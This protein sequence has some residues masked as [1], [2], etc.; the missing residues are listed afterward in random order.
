MRVLILTPLYPGTIGKDV[1]AAYRRLEVMIAAIAKIADRLEIVHFVHPDY[2]LLELGSQQLNREQSEYW[3]TRVEVSLAPLRHYSKRRWWHR[4]LAILSYSYRD[5][6]F[7]FSGVEQV[8]ALE[9]LLDRQPDMIFVHRLACMS[10]V[11]RLRRKLPRLVCDLDDV[12]HRKQIRSALASRSWLPKGDGLLK[13][14]AIFLAER[15]A[16]RL[17]ARLFVC[18]DHDRHYLQRL[19]FGD[20]VVTIPNSVPMPK[21]YPPLPP[22]QTVLFLGYLP[23]KPNAEAAERLISTIW[24]LVQRECPSARLIVAGKS[25]QSI[26]SYGLHPKNV[27]FT[28][29]VDDLD[30]LY[31]RSRLVCCPL[32]NGG[33]TRVKL[34]E[35]AGYAKPMVSTTVGAEGLAFADGSEILIRDDDA[36][37]AEACIRLLKDDALCMRLGQAARQKAKSLYDISSV[38]D[39]V[40]S[41]MAKILGSANISN[42]RPTLS[43][44]T[45]A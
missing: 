41:E 2:P 14:P 11:F 24:P 37:V 9:E 8:R 13:V 21:A 35:A 36:S 3:G 33:G 6:P 4:L 39:G 42:A 29:F 30:M 22:A 45:S 26:P 34:I 32:I 15:K 25:P 18:S 5:E 20:A 16:A 28:G 38:R 7:R 12:E 19:G 27:E 17:A 1:Q 40:V 44:E 23:Y 31:A 43:V 10:T